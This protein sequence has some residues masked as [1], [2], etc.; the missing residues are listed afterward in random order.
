MFK[1][2]VQLKVRLVTALERLLIVLVAGLVLDVLWQVASRFLLRSPSSWTDELATL[3]IIWVAMLG[4]SVA[5]IR[6]HH[7][8]VDYFVGKLAPRARLITQIIVQ[9]LIALFAGVILVWGGAKLVELTLLTDQVSPALGVK[10]G[11]VYLALPI[12]GVVILLVA[13]ETAAEKLRTLK[14]HPVEDAP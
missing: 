9:A 1:L 8:G 3:L 7:L 12:S 11:Y 2:L 6:N 13:I 10:M 4:A 5:F 14:S